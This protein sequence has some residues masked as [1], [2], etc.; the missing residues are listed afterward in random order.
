[1]KLFFIMVLRR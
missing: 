1:M